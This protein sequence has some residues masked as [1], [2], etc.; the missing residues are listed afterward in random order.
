[1]NLFSSKRNQLSLEKIIKATETK[2]NH[3]FNPNKSKV[4]EENNNKKT[5]SLQESKFDLKQ[6][7]KNYSLFR[8]SRLNGFTRKYIELFTDLLYEN[9]SKNY[10]AKRLSL[11]NY[12]KN[13]IKKNITLSFE[14]F[15]RR[16]SPRDN[17]KQENIYITDINKNLYNSKFK[18]KNKF[19]LKNLL[20]KNQLKEGKSS[21]NF[22]KRINLKINMEE[23]PFSR[24]KKINKYKSF[25][26][27]TFPFNKTK[28]NSNHR[29]KTINSYTYKKNNDD[30]DDKKYMW[31]MNPK[32]E[33]IEKN[34]RTK[35]ID[36]LNKQYD[37]YKYRT[38]KEKKNTKEIRKRQFVYSNDKLDKIKIHKRVEFPFKNEF[39]AKLNRLNINRVNL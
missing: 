15:I 5:Y 6:I 38:I 19:N 33:L 32:D 7:L 23:T 21:I 17:F 29:L 10:S 30:D 1:M 16:E 18:H 8:E 31:E 34:N 27:I 37:F 14:D 22:L 2:Y 28:I 3:K 13:I 9:D 36:Y 39:F 4:Y 24:N 20:K 35:F 25:S 11:V 12:R 26:R